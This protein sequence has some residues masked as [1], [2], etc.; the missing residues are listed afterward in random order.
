MSDTQMQKPDLFSIAKCFSG[1]TF[2]RHL[3]IQIVFGILPD[4]REK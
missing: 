1:N 3:K 2:Q 4:L